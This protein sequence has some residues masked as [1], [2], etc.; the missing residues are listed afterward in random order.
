MSQTSFP[1]IVLLNVIPF[2]GLHFRGRKDFVR[3]FLLREE[4]LGT[5]KSVLTVSFG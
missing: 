2:E 3:L 1:T 5:T 4:I